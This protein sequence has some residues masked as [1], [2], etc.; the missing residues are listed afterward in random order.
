[1]RLY[2]SS[3]YLIDTACAPNGNNTQNQYRSIIRREITSSELYALRVNDVDDLGR[4]S[5]GVS[6]LNVGNTDGST[7]LDQ[8]SFEVFT[9]NVCGEADK[10]HFTSDAKSVISIVMEIDEGSVI[11]PTLELYDPLGRLIRVASDGRLLQ[12]LP[13]SGTYVVL[14][15]SAT[16][17][18]GGY[19]MLFNPSGTTTTTTST[20]TRTSTTTQTTIVVTSTLPLQ[21]HL[22]GD[23]DNSGSIV[24]SDALRLLSIAVGIPATAYCPGYCPVP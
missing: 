16:S 22:C 19:R 21:C 20:T 23:L 8:T 2:D 1:M 4:G 6:I 12:Q 15:Y 10:Y 17:E 5:V 24:A 3:E 9:I 18:T 11:R 14:A 13:I 7:E